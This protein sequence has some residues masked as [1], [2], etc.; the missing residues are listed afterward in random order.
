MEKLIQDRRG[1]KVYCS[2]MR[3]KGEPGTFKDRVLLEETP[4]S[5][6]EGMLIAGY[7]FGSKQGYIYIRGEYRRIQ[8]I[9]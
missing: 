5:V 6:I 8:K 7:V 2:A 9:F 4:L 1:Y 3:T